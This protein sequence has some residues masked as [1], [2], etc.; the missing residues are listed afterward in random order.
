MLNE[1]MM[2]KLLAMRLHG[3]VEGLKSQEQDRTV[4]EL[5][6][7][8][9]FSLLIDQQWNWRENQV[10][11]RRLK[12][13]KLR[14]S[15]CVEDIDYRAARGLDKG[16]VRSLAKDS[17]WVRNHENIFVIGPCGVGKSFIA[18]AL[19]QKAC[20]DGHS[21]FYVRAAALFRDLALA[22]A[23]GSLRNLLARLSRIDVLVID[24]WAMAP[25]SAPERRDVWEI[26][27]DRYQTRSTIL[28]SQLPVSRWHEQIGDPTIADGILDRLVHNAH[29]IEM[30]GESMRK[31][32]GKSESSQ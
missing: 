19:A 30:R 29:R 28:T 12:A 21:A 10:L 2:E 14:G 25:L 17:A 22:R 7:M 20:R 8:E 5:S 1:P 24:D 16:V 18:L 11:A 32:C 15:A 13:A 27:E 9:R 26:C 6:F 3:M 31:N 23:D 4:H